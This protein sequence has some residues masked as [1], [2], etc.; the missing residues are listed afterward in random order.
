MI[1]RDDRC[2][3]VWN[4][5][6]AF[7]DRVEDVGHERPNEHVLQ[8]SEQH[9]D[10]EPQVI[11]SLSATGATAAYQADALGAVQHPL[12]IPGAAELVPDPLGGLTTHLYRPLPTRDVH[13]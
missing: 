4:M 11:D 2:I 13:Q 10:Q 12:P 5:L 8:D 9:E 6:R 3:L 7:G 1:A